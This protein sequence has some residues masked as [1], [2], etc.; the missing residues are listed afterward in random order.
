MIKT[1]AQRGCNWPDSVTF[2][3][4]QFPDLTP[5]PVFVTTGLYCPSEGQRGWGE[6][7]L[8]IQKIE[9]KKTEQ[10]LGW[11]MLAKALV[12][13]WAI[14]P[15]TIPGLLRLLSYRCWDGLS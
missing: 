11:L 2:R 12:R 1:V 3:Q 15:A 10:Q 5:E 14:F 7:L 6:H 13:S 9:G 4:D 8:G